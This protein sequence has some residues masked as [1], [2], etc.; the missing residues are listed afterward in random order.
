MFLSQIVQHLPTLPRDSADGDAW[1]AAWQRALASAHSRSS[2]DAVAWQL[3][4]WRVA[5]LTGEVRESR[6]IERERK[7]RE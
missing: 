6:E 3:A 7:E 2:A 4:A 5:E 1:H